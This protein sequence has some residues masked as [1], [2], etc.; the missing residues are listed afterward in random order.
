VPANG[1]LYPP[2]GVPDDLT[3]EALG[4]DNSFLP[5]PISGRVQAFVRK[6]GGGMP[7]PRCIAKITT[8]KMDCTY[9]VTCWEFH[10]ATSSVYSYM[11][12]P[13]VL[14]AKFHPSKRS[15]KHMK[16]ND[17]NDIVSQNKTMFKPFIENRERRVRDNPIYLFCVSEKVST[18]PHFTPISG[19]HVFQ[20]CT[21]AFTW[22]KYQARWFEEF[23]HVTGTPIRGEYDI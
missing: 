20:K 6:L 18:F 10:F 3:D 9:R 16:R 7:R 2:L 4:L 19:W 21:I 8:L 12:H 22:I 11:F 5:E 1:L 17:V 14:S 15:E 23:N 13:A